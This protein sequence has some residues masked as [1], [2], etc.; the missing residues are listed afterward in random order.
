MSVYN[1]QPQVTFTIEITKNLGRIDKI[2][3]LIRLVPILPNWEVELRRTALVN[4]VHYSTK[5]EGN[6]LSLN[7][8]QKLLSG[9]KARGSDKD[10][11]EVF[12]LQRAI[13][14]V[15]E[16]AVKTDVQ[17]NGNRLYSL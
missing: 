2:R 12:N 17:I 6:A 7:N 8:V 16:V 10:K 3:D 9:R 4:T 11:Q 13:E 14:F 5:I 1:F 15:D